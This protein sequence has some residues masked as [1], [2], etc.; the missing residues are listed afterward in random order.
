MSSSHSIKAQN[1]SSPFPE[2]STISSTMAAIAMNMTWTTSMATSIPRMTV[3]LIVSR[4]ITMLSAY[5][6]QLTS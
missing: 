6:G 4:T 2:S 3:W 5:S 1:R